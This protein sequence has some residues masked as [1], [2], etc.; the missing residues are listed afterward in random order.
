MEVPGGPDG[1]IYGAVGDQDGVMAAARANMSIQR[2]FSKSAVLTLTDP[3]L[4]RGNTVLHRRADAQEYA[5]R[6]VHTT[7]LALMPFLFFCASL[8]FTVW[9]TGSSNQVEFVFLYLVCAMALILYG[10]AIIRSQGRQQTRTH[11]RRWTGRL[12]QVATIFGVLVGA[13]IFYKH[14]IFYRVYM[15]MNTYTNIAV[16]QPLD[17]FVDAGMIAFTSNTILD[18]TRAVGF[19]SAAADAFFCVA[20]ILDGSMG[21]EQEV[22]Y[23]AVGV[24]CCQPRASFQCDDAS[25]AS[26]KNALM[27]LEPRMLTSPLMEWAVAGAV[28][29]T[30]FDAAIRMQAAA[31]ETV[32][33][34]KTRLVY[35][36]KDPEAHAKQHYNR[37]VEAMIIAIVIYFFTSILVAW[38][39]M[40]APKWLVL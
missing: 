12:S 22:H 25:D 37:G 29:R 39:H 14:F 35:W 19:K 20:P 11:W 31:F 36:T 2:A 27:M 7:V 30:E 34:P 4:E 13:Y 15:G 8:G 26:T 24:G 21:L 28:D 33:A 38:F 9:V 10:T 40:F 17:Q 32:V 3:L 6:V 1:R 16:S 23:F 18:V 5:M